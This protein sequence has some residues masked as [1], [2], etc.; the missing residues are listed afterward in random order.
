[1]KLG[2]HSS[3]ELK[4]YDVIQTKR[5]V[6]LKPRSHARKQFQR[7]NVRPPPLHNVMTSEMCVRH[8]AT[9]LFSY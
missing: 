4:S 1:M 9:V 2:L 5:P 6:A 8:D 7:R 3:T